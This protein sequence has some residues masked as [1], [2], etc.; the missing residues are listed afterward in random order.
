MDYEL[1]PDDAW[2]RHSRYQRARG[3]HENLMR[4]LCPVC[5]NDLMDTCI[6]PEFERNEFRLERLAHRPT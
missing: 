1:D 2:D 5:P 3:Y 4:M 6:D